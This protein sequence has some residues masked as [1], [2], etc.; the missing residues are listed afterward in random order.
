MMT[1]YPYSFFFP[2]ESENIIPSHL[3]LSYA[4]TANKIMIIKHFNVTIID[5]IKN[6]KIILMIK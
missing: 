5:T 6:V 4:F 3:F 2:F 1:M